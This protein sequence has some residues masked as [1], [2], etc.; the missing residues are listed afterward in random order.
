[1]VVACIY[2]FCIVFFEEHQLSESISTHDSGCPRAQLVLFAPHLYGRSSILPK[3][4]SIRAITGFAGRA[5]AAF[6]ACSGRAAFAAQSGAGAAGAASVRTLHSARPSWY[7]EA[8][9]MD[10]DRSERPIAAH[11]DSSQAVR[12]RGMCVCMW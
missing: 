2:F 7:S 1:V 6:Y 10:V 5:Q 3:M 4:S 9:A 12:M 11:M 8:A